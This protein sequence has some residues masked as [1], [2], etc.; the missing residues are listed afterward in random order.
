M[1]LAVNDPWEDVQDLLEEKHLGADESPETL[2]LKVLSDEISSA[3]LD[4]SLA[5]SLAR[6]VD[7]GHVTSAQLQG[8]M[9]ET[10]D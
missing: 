3:L 6:P 9:T 5:S 7:V 1:S 2:F 10:T 4:P 8:S